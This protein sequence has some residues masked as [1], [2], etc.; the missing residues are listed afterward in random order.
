M[1]TCVSCVGNSRLLLGSLLFPPHICFLSA[2]GFTKLRNCPRKASAG[3]VNGLTAY[4]PHAQVSPLWTMGFER[5]WGGHDSSYNSINMSEGAFRTE[6]PEC[7]ETGT[8]CNSALYKR[9]AMCLPSQGH[10]SQGVLPGDLHHPGLKSG[11]SRGCTS[12]SSWRNSKHSQNG[13]LHPTS[14]GLPT[15]SEAVLSIWISHLN[16][17][18]HWKIAVLHRT[19]PLSTRQLKKRPQKHRMTHS[20]CFFTHT[21]A[22]RNSNTRKPAPI[23]SFRLI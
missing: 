20:S 22:M 5:Q 10:H 2:I 15:S 9:C 6:P 7:G 3:S 11:S 14:N 17:G 23:Y 18:S 21:R 12:C 19:R 1:M 4:E 8:L 13:L 16:C